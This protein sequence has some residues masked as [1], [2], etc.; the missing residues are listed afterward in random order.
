MTTIIIFLFPPSFSSL[1]TF[2]RPS[3]LFSLPLSLRVFFTSSSEHYPSANIIISTLPPT[4][5]FNHITNITFPLLHI[6]NI[7][8][9]V[10]FSFPLFFSFITLHLIPF[11]SLIFFLLVFLSTNHM[12]VLLTCKI[13]IRYIPSQFHI[14]NKLMQT[15][16]TSKLPSIQIDPDNKESNTS[17][18]HNT[19]IYAKKFAIR[20]I[21]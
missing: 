13:I 20:S 1:S 5:F 9:S 8:V 17:L 18:S 10:C 19:S 21:F 12:K 14:S 16:G 6:M 4:N 11:L 3:S 15:E 2:S 7:S